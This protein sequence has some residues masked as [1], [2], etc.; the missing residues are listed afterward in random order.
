MNATSPSRSPSNLQLVIRGQQEVARQNCTQ[1]LQL[2]HVHPRCPLCQRH[3]PDAP[4][5]DS[6]LP[7][8]AFSYVQRSLEPD[9]FASLQP[10]P[11]NSRPSTPVQAER[12]RE[13]SE[14]S[15]VPGAQ[16]A[17]DILAVLMYDAG[18]FSKFFSKQRSLGK[19]ARGTVYLVQHVLEQHQL[20][21]Y[22][23]KIVS[24]G[25]SSASLVS[26][27]REIKHLESLRHRNI[28]SYHFAWLESFQTTPFAPEVPHLFILMSFANGGSMEDFIAARR[29]RQQGSSETT[30]DLRKQAFKASR[31][32]KQR[33]MAVHYLRVDEICALFR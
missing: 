27:L 21:F 25:D 31:G 5:Q 15:F 20:G 24:V 1:E 23:C 3:L 7:D 29:N 4:Q 9:Y 32:A 13:L 14:D 28:I 30:G 8:S 12:D 18:Y 19:G 16:R 10:T 26:S 22:A 17:V 11:E 33:Q 6:R 2:S